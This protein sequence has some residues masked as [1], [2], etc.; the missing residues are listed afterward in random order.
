[1]WM[2]TVRGCAYASAYDERDETLI[3]KTLGKYR[4]IEHQGRG[5]MA[6]VYKAYHPDLDRHVAIK[7]L[8]PFLAEEEN[9]LARFQREAKIVAAFRHPNIVQVYDF[10]FSAEDDVY[11]MV[12]EFIDGPSLKARLEEMAREGQRFSQEEAIRIVTAVADALDY[13]HRHGMVHRDI[14]PANIM[15][16]EE[17]QPILTDFGIAKIVNTSTLTAS[18]AMVGTPAYMAPEQGIGQAGDER[19]DIYSLGVVLY[20]LLTGSLPFDAD[21]PLGIVL[22]HINTPLTPPSVLNPD[23]SPDVEAVVMRAL[24]KDPDKRYQSAREFSADLERCLAGESVKPVSPEIAMPPVMVS[25]QGQEGEREWEWPTLHTPVISLA[26]PQAEVQA[27][28][29]PRPRRYWVAA[30]VVV[31]ALMLVGGIALFTAGIPRHLFA[32]LLSRMVTPTPAVIGTPTPTYP[33]DL[34]ATYY[35]NATQFAAWMAT[36]EATTGVTLTPS[37]APPTPD[38]T[39]TALSACVFDMEVTEDQPVSPSVLTPRRQFVK[40]WVIENTGTCPW[41]EGVQLVF[42]SG[43]EV[44]VMGGPQ[45]ELLAPGETVEVEIA[46]RAPASYGDY[47]SGWQLQDSDGNS[48]GEMLE[49]AFRVG[50]TPTPWPTATPKPTVT[51]TATPTPLYSPTPMEPLRIDSAGIVHGTFH[52]LASG[53]W[54]ADIYVVARG[55][56]GQY[57]FYRDVIS[58]DTEFFAPNPSEPW[59]G[60]LHG[61]RWTVCKDM[62]ISF[63]VTS[64]GA[65]AHRDYI[66][67]YPEECP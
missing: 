42:V 35:A 63:W 53:E 8:H 20:Q 45:V 13:A 62:W 6:E 3:G 64:A 7:V 51:A 46:F 38:L 19:S 59:V 40:H 44:E 43:D 57:R 34:T 48:I 61:A 65:Q 1:M 5:G 22:K 15:F 60:V 58:P 47:I 18:G 26:Q 30:L 41:P 4:I 27:A 29:A 33:P 10:E 31:A 54:E 17:G 23:L 67:P 2:G 21:T 50:P 12:M 24:A 66:I 11:Y 56:D 52:K 28:P 16:T 49:V 32:A 37:P 14:K 55:G 25:S 36:Y 9:F 39:A